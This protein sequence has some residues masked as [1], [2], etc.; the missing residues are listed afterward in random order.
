MGQGKDWYSGDHRL[1]LTA[2]RQP[3]ADEGRWAALLSCL[4]STPHPR[5]CKQ[6][7]FKIEQCSY[8]TTMPPLCDSRT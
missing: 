5:V 2:L 8:Y 4:W 7:V 1:Q 3:R 6:F